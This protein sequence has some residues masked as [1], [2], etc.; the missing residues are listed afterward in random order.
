MEKCISKTNSMK[1]LIE[2]INGLDMSSAEK[3]AAIEDVL[4]AERV[5]G[6]THEV[7]AFVSRLA[8]IIV[9]TPA[10]R[11]LASSWAS[12]AWRRWTP[13]SARNRKPSGRPAP[14]Q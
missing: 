13:P 4:R 5:A 8:R 14:S 12:A 6:F 7:A 10:R 11:R 9:G 3:Q 2:Q 1:N